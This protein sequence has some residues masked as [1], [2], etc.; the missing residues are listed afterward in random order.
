MKVC[1][2]TRVMPAHLKGGMQ[3]HI[4]MLCKGLSG[5]GLEVTV[6]TTRHPDGI[7]FEDIGGVKIHYLGNT[8]AGEYS[9]QWWKESLNKFIELHDLNKFDVVHTQSG[10]GYSFLKEKLNDVYKCPVVLS[11]HGTSL[12]EI[13][14][15]LNFGLSIKNPVKSLKI[16]ASIARYVYSYLTYEQILVKR[17]DA[18]IA[19]S[20]EQENIIKKL[21]SIDS[22]RIFRVFNGIDV[23]FFIPSKKSGEI[24][25]QD[26]N[27]PLS[28]NFLLSVAR[29]EKDKGIQNIIAALPY[30]LKELP[31][32]KLMVVGDGSY[33]SLL[34]KQVELLNLEKSVIFT[35]MVPFESLPDYFNACDVFV[36]PTIRQ[37][38]YDLTI[39]EAMA[40]EKP[41][42]VSNI[43]SVPTVIEDD[44]DGILVPT[45]DVNK[46]A[47]AVIMVLKDK[48]L[49]QRLGK[50][51]RNKVV[52]KFSVESMVDGTIKVYEEVI[53]RHKEKLR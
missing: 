17:S 41:V 45:G 6:I 4:L 21:Y 7:G 52:E 33:A 50:A 16:F 46:L 18:V 48:E 47:E 36:N 37:N 49:A 24:I 28:A 19:T 3:D 42:V 39:L 44:V 15:R 31:D 38:G 2:F 30:I 8:S 26:Y 10:G 34:K 9:N 35:G 14:T 29:L 12:D 32:T 23:S 51:A 5:R 1:M 27:I 22:D 40:C 13:K 11:L 43:G 20:Y 53:R 25:G